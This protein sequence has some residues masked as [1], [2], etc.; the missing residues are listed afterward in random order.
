MARWRDE[1]LDDTCSYYTTKMVQVRDGRLGLIYYASIILCLLYLGF[2]IVLNRGYLDY[3][4]ILGSLDFDLI[5]SIEHLRPPATYPYCEAAAKVPLVH[6]PNASVGCLF[7][8]G[9]DLVFPA[10][11]EAAIFV[12]TRVTD[13]E[14]K[15]R[16]GVDALDCTDGPLWETVSGQDNYAVG[17]EDFNVTILHSIYLPTGMGFHSGDS[18]DMDGVYLDHK[19]RP[20]GYAPRGDMDVLRLGDLLKAAGVSL[21]D[22]AH[23]PAQEV[24]AHASHGHG[25]SGGPTDWPPS[26][27]AGGRPL[28]VRDTGIALVVVLDYSNTYRMLLPAREPQYTLSVFRLSQDSS[29]VNDIS[30]QWHGKER[31]RRHRS[32]VRIIATRKG[33]LGYF[34]LRALLLNIASGLVI[35]RT[36][37]FVV[38]LVAVWVHPDRGRYFS[39]IYEQTELRTHL[40]RKERRLKAQVVGSLLHTRRTNSGSSAS[41]AASRLRKRPARAG[42]GDGAWQRLEEGM[43]HG[44]GPPT[45]AAAP[46]F[47]TTVW[48]GASTALRALMRMGERSLGLPASSDELWAATTLQSAFRGKVARDRLRR[49]KTELSLIRSATSASGLRAA[50]GQMAWLT[51]GAQSSAGIVVSA[52]IAAGAERQSDPGSNAQYCGVRSA[53]SPFRTP[54]SSRGQ[55]P[56][57]PAAAHACDAVLMSEHQ[58]EQW[59]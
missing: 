53:S 16:C 52:N 11:E 13:L 50:P 21:D 9:H 47:L 57:P 42:F 24:L 3:T 38:D 22:P 17:V 51:R 39:Y 29:A 18:H 20:F 7:M 25:E 55:S 12:S 45:H 34:S 27:S 46:S 28:T 15:L 2:N 23:D 35:V 8:D 40:H 10:H 58:S 49:R 48:R 44:E 4:P 32:G 43:P 56:G 26:F 14:Q 6:A 37:K 41:D 19:G 30:Y 1:D 59:L 31:V 33:T 36:A 54:H 5:G